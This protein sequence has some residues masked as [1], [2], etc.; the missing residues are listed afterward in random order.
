MLSERPLGRTHEVRV[1]GRAT[2][3]ELRHLLGA[4]LLGL[5]LQC[6]DRQRGAGQ[7]ETAGKEAVPQFAR[8][9]RL[10][11]GLIAHGLDL[12]LAEPHHRNHLLCL[13][14]VGL[15]C[16]LHELAP[17]LGQP[18]ALLKREALRRTERRKLATGHARSRRS[19]TALLSLLVPEPLEAAH[20]GHEDRRLADVQL[21]ELL[22]GADLR[23]LEQVVSEHFAGLLDHRPRFFMLFR[24]AQHAKPLGALS[25]EEQREGRRLVLQHVLDITFRKRKAHHA[26]ENVF[27]F[28]CLPLR[29]SQL[30]REHRL[31]VL[32]LGV[33]VGL[34]FD[35]ALCQVVAPDGDSVV[36]R[37]AA[38]LVLRLDIRPASDQVATQHQM[39]SGAG[40]QQRCPAKLISLLDFCLLFQQE[41]NALGM[42]VECG[43]QQWLRAKLGVRQ[44][45]LCPLGARRGDAFYVALFCCLVKPS[46]RCLHE[47]LVHI[48]PDS[49]WIR[50]RHG[51]DACEGPC[52]PTLSRQI[53]S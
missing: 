6:I 12:V 43:H 46:L 28:L 53:D 2:P 10:R 8:A 24:P 32:G 26:G 34:L 4:L 39:A 41:V 42:A 47:P 22:L 38:E 29:P 49:S 50:K 25:G 11:G 35:Q 13:L 16:C 17:Q 40:G 1:E 51:L 27:Q 45:Q 5:C 9:T 21:A 20:R 30:Y 14:P 15:H 23:D 31:A 7:H 37:S 18:H 36:Q 19:V 48:E 52:K 44:V 3:L 33:H